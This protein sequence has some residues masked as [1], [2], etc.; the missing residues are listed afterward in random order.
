MARAYTTKMKS[1]AFLTLD[2]VG[3]YVIDDEHAIAPLEALGWSVSTISWRQTGIP[4]SHFD[5]VIIRSTWDYWDDTD[6]FLSV[7]ETIDRESRLANPIELVRWNYQKTYMRDLASRGVKIVP[8]LFPE[9][10]SAGK[11]RAWFEQHQCEQLVIKPVVGANG[12]DA[13]RVSIDTGTERLE[14]ITERFRIKPAQ[15]QPFMPHILDEGEFSLFYFNGDFSHAILKVPARGEF[16]SQEEHGSEIL[17]V[18]PEE[19]LQLRGRL[20]LAAIGDAP[21]YARIDFV[22]DRSGDFALMEQELIE[23]SMYLRMHPAAPERFARAIDQRFAGAVA[24]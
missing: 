4:W 1:C 22:R 11:F 9:S 20:A 2:E 16:R 8:T 5:A 19:Q 23:P 10:V 7:L 24:E 13:F 18:E 12:D 15:V 21:L 6:A 14:E 3:D 17:A